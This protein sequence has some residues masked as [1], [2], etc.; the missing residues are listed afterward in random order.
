LT[1]GLPSIQP[2]CRR[3]SSNLS[4]TAISLR[5]GTQ[6]PDISQGVDTGG[7]GDQGLMFGFACNE[8]KELMPLPIQL[9]HALT[10][11]L[12]TVRK[13]DSLPYLRPDGKAQVTIEYVDGKPNR[14]DTIV[15]STQHGPMVHGETDNTRIQH[16]IAADMREFVIDEVFK[17]SPVKA[18]VVVTEFCF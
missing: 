2:A 1:S 11:Q 5:T 13:N 17:N 15:I 18:E 6:S 9:A 3:L 8:T 10:R 14:I 12:A 7:A 16:L 4:P